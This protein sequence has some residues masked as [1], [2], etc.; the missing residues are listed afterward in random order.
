MVGLLFLGGMRFK[1]SLEK[2][3]SG[4]LQHLLTAMSRVKT[5]APQH[6]SGAFVP[7]IG[8]LFLLNLS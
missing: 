1:Q 6:T 2:R 3:R 4:G 5:A 7:I 8:S